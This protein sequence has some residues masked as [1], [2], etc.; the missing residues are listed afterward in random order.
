MLRDQPSTETLRQELEIFL[1]NAKEND[2][3]WL[4]DTQGH[5]LSLQ[6]GGILTLIDMNR[7]SKKPS[8]SIEETVNAFQLLIDGRLEVLRSTFK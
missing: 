5:I 7:Q 1:R 3:I 4:D 2:E 6:T 8:G